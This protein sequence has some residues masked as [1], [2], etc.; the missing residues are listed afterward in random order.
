MKRLGDKTMTLD[1][2]WH[3]YK[4]IINF[5]SGSKLICLEH[6]IPTE[7]PIVDEGFTDKPLFFFTLFQ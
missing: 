3:W 6:F 7:I 4:T 1:L 2:Q 5:L